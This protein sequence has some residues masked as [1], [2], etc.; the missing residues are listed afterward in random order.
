M[1]YIAGIGVA[2]PPQSLSQ[3]QYCQYAKD[4]CCD[5]P[6]K[7]KI[8]ERLYKRT[9]IAR[10][11]IALLSAD[12]GKEQFYTLKPHNYST[13][14][15]TSERM[16]FYA[17]EALPLALP[18]AQRALQKAAMAPELV[19][20]LITVSCTGFVAPGVD[21]S[22]IQSLHLSPEIGRTHV[23]FMGCH[24]CLNALRVA[25]AYCQAGSAPVLVCAVELCSLHFQ[26]GWQ[27]DYLL[28]NSLFSDGAAALL[29]TSKDGSGAWRLAASGSYIVPDSAS[30]M[31]WSIGDHGFAMT[32]SSAV[33]TLVHLNLRTWLESWL[34]NHGLSISDIKSWAVHPGGPRILDA[35]QESLNLS[36][37]ALTTSREIFSEC[38]N[39][40]SPTVIF[41]LERLQQRGQT[42]P[43]VM[44]GFGPG[45]T[46]EAALLL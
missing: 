46:I 39:M 21:C 10:R 42:P 13:G 26:F 4:A 7:V 37:S 5:T 44:L 17:R 35:V 29:L 3:E 22:L 38:G 41:I 27:T 8:L 30:A 40:S 14:P 2:L 43:C 23:G 12:D 6:A 18:A 45:L 20:Q 25:S 32:L 1:A 16:S 24:G 34:H 36:G 28:A 11:S 31:T 33:P 15:S 19:K 9:E